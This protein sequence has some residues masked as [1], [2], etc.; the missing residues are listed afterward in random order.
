MSGMLDVDID[1][2]GVY[3]VY[4]NI[5]ERFGIKFERFIQLVNNGQW[6]VIM[7]EGRSKR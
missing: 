2:L 3:F 7:N 4:H 6:E 1:K 5:L